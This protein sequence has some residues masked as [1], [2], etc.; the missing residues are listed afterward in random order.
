MAN[1]YTNVISIHREKTLSITPSLIRPEAAKNEQPLMIYGGKGLSRF[2]FC[3]I[4]ENKNRVI[5][6]MRASEAGMMLEKSR[7]AAFLQTQAACAAKADASSPAYVYRFKMG[8]LKGRTPAEIL[9]NDADGAAKLQQM[10]GYL[11]QNVNRFRANQQG[12]DAINDAFN[13]LNAGKLNADNLSSSSDIVLYDASMRS[14]RSK[15]RQDGMLLIY[16][17]R[18]VWSVGA[19]KPVNVTIENYYAPVMQTPQGLLQINYA[20]R[21]KSTELKIG[22]NLSEAEWFTVR[23]SMQYTIDMFKNASMPVSYAEVKQHENAWRQNTQQS[24][25]YGYAGQSAYQGSA[26]GQPAP[27]APDTGYAP[28]YAEQP[29]YYQ[30]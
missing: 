1:D 23:E 25:S 30:N 11:Q 28:G 5:A 6:N 15:Q 24:A 21:D 12:M 26:Q 22:M 17:F 19:E 27:A 7:H 14:L 10:F 13:L 2:A 20:A 29:Q 3:L 18:I 8:N 16:T 4:D 9:L